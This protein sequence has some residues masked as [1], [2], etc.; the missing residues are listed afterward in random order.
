M[1]TS[2]YKRRLV[3]LLGLLAG[4]ACSGSPRPSPREEP[5]PPPSWMHGVWTREWIEV[6]GVR[7]SRFAVQYLQ[8]PTLFAD[9]RLPIE[10][11]S[12]SRATSFAD[13]TDAELLLLARQRGFAG[14]VTAVADTITWHHEIDFQPRDGTADIGR[15]ERVGPGQIYE[16]ALDSSYVESWRSVA[17]GDSAFLVVRM[18]QWSVSINTLPK[19]QLAGLFP[20]NH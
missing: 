11:P 7:S 9:M 15:V 2:A 5:V 12:F 6:R 13:L 16:H 10:R 14:R 20:S 19:A 4:H 8:T 1:D 17:S 18:E 3:V